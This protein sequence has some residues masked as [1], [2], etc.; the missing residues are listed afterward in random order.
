VYGK[1]NR[2]ICYVTGAEQDIDDLISGADIRE[3]VIH[4]IQ[5]DH[6]DFNDDSYIST[7]EL[8][9]YR[10]RHMENIVK[11]E[12]GQVTALEKQVLQKLEANKFVADNVE[13]EIESES[14]F[15]DRLSD[16]IAEFGGSWKFII[17]FLSMMAG[18]MILNVLVY[19]EKGFDPYPFIFLNL[20]LS[21][22]AALQAPIIMMSQNRQ[23]DKDRIRSEH[24]YQVNLSAELQIRMLHEKLDHLMHNQHREMIEIQ[25]IQ[26]E[27][28]QELEEKVDKLN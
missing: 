1:K 13:P 20:I 2:G 18:W 4:E 17:S 5:K 3:A 24:D 15:A 6:P 26:I 12:V 14:S 8:F 21:C 25:E 11:K 9:K 7:R 16:K 22:L 28:M 23:A 19:H 10:Q 27:L